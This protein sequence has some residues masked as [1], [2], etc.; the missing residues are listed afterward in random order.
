VSFV[1]LLEDVGLARVELAIHA[2]DD[3][4]AGSGKVIALQR[5]DDDVV[6]SYI[7]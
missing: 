6:V 2:P 1:G 5:G 7:G 3:P 4:V